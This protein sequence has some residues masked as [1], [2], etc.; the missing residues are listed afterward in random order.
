MR[1]EITAVILAGGKATRMGGVDKGLQLFQGKPLIEHILHRLQS[2]V[3]LIMI[4]ANRHQQ[5]YAQYGFEVFSDERPNFQGPLSGI[6]TALEKITTP[7]CLFV[8]C[9]NPILPL[10]LME[11]LYL[12]LQKEK[13]LL[14]YAFDGER[15]HPTY[16]LAS[17][18]IHPQLR[19]YLNQGERKMMLFMQQVQALPVNFSAEK[20]QFQNLNTLEALSAL[21]SQSL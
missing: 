12:N 6:L 7:Y 16:C 5:D 17:Q 10:N 1:T 11:K 4:N 9:D 19:H 15:P 3:D 2:Q 14:A 21:H 8:P 20:N 13:A 18:A